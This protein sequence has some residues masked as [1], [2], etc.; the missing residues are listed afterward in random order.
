MKKTVVINYVKEWKVQEG[1][2]IPETGYK[3]VDNTFIKQ[4][5]NAIYL[6]AGLNKSARDLLDYLIRLMDNQ[7]MVAS[8]FK[9]RDDFISFVS[10]CTDGDIMYTH[11]TVKKAFATLLKKELI[12]Q[13]EKR[14][15]YKVNPEY[16]FK[17]GNRERI[18]EISLVLSRKALK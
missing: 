2:K 13:G 17:E 10:K 18:E 7:N 1:I 8:N 16:F 5:N 11:N 6:L 9:I 12:L 14:G 4:Y 15:L 3:K